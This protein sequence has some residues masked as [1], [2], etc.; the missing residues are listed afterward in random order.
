VI[1]P[2]SHLATPSATIAAMT[3]ALRLVLG[4]ARM[5]PAS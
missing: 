3:I 2:E 4:S 1:R 5:I